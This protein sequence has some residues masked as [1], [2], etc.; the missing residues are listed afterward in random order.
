MSLNVTSTGPRQL[1]R[2]AAGALAALMALALPASAQTPAA[3]AAAPPAAPS[4]QGPA[5]MLIMDGSGSMW[6]KLDGSKEPKFAAAREALRAPLGKIAAK[7][8]L[9]LMSYGH[10]RQGTCGDI[11]VIAA[12]EQGLPERVTAPLEK[13]SPKGKGPVAQALREAGKALAGKGPASVLLVHDNADNCQQDLCAAAEELGKAQIKVLAVGIGLEGE[14]AGRMACVAKATGGRF[15]NATDAA[16]LTSMLAESVDLAMLGRGD[17]AGTDKR[18]EPSKEE[19]LRVPKALPP[20]APPGLGLAALLGTPEGGIVDNV[21][22]RVT[23][24]GGA[25]VIDRTAAEV[26]ERLPAGKYAVEAR[27]GLVSARQTVEVGAQGAT[28]V[29]LPLQ[30]GLVK[31]AARAAK[32][33]DPLGGALLSLLP[34]ASDKKAAAGVA[35]L[36][37]GRSGETALVVPPGDYVVR[38]EIGLVR[39]DTPVT[40]GAGARLVPDIVLGAGRLQLSASAIEDGEA[41][42]GVTFVIAEDDPDSPQGRREVARSAASKPEFVL[43]AGTYYATARLGPNEGRQRFAVGAG[44]TVKKAIS[45]GLSKL[46]VNL[47]MDGAAGKSDL[48]VSVRVSRLDTPPKEVGRSG[49][50]RAEFLLMPGRYR[51][52]VL[53]GAQNAR[54]EGEVELKP[55]HNAQ[56]SVKLDAAAVTLRAIE[57][58]G[59]PASPDAFWEIRDTRGRVVWRTSQAEPKAL[60]APGRY[61]VRSELRARSLEKTVDLAAGEARNVEVGP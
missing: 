51:I 24:D 12:P 32:A 6:G 34:A 4:A 40:V 26:F 57:A 14:E 39:Q 2:A 52:E 43:P 19:A 3:P 36:W 61:V 44:D 28:Q 45:L 54:A 58:A 53:A 10:R 60:L 35:P 16:A 48:P 41:L 20:D 1:S 33:A 29:K 50:R 47:A 42:D 56:A 21:H 37:I 59:G 49:E 38:T 9:G 27:A 15:V 23:K 46:T 11:E 5:I 22:W 18:S 31:M 17:A 30:A 8:R 25:V 55:G 7:A 13:L